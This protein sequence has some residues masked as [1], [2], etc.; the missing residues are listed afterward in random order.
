VKQ[1]RLQVL[2]DAL[3]SSAVKLQ[4]LQSDGNKVK[5]GKKKVSLGKSD[6]VAALLRMTDYSYWRIFWIT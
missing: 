1:S 5:K 2:S 4:T 6:N 3:T